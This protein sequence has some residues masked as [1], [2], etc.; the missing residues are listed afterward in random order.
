[1]AQPVAITPRWQ[2]DFPAAVNGKAGESTAVPVADGS[3]MVVVVAPGADASSP[4]LLLGSRSVPVKLIGHD[5]VS[6]L[7]FIKADAG[8]MPKAMEWAEEAGVS[9]GTSLQSMES[10]GPVKCL[11]AGWVKQVGGKILPLALLRI[12]FSRSVPPP[13]TPLADQ[14]GRIVGIVFQGSGSGNTGYAIPA[15]AVHRVRHDVCNGGR[16][17]RGWLGLALRMDSQT[18]QISR[19]L[20]ESPAI[21]AGIKANDVLLSIGSRQVA[22]YA[23]AANAFF[24]L[25]PGQPVRV[26]LLRDA[27]QLEFTL[28]P[29]TPKG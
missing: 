25:I 13:G 9:S 8:G 28:T 27:E 20:P 2:V 1:M 18:P 12:N 6:R 16:L 24:Y 17:N 29:T 4:Q 21:A 22:D 7:G 5:P 3:L 19:V 14:S 26:K 11:A 15:E 10:G 23:D